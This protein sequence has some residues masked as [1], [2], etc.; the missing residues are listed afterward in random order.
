MKKSGEKAGDAAE[1]N[2][3][4]GFR[5]KDIVAMELL[6]MVTALL[7][8]ALCIL[9]LIGLLRNWWVLS[10]VLILGILLNVTL[11][12]TSL[13]RKKTAL[14]AFCLLMVLALVGSLIYFTL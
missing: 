8:D 3:G 10:F 11:A 2:V 14:W 9:F 7:L 4:A 5:K 13:V 6:C 1:K 12:V